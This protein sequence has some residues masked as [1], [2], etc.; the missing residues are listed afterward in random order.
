MQPANLRGCKVLA[1]PIHPPEHSE[2]KRAPDEGVVKP[3]KQLMQAPTDAYWP[4]GQ[5]GTTHSGA[6]EPGAQTA[7]G[8]RNEKGHHMRGHQGL[9]CL[10]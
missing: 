8:E 10:H 7:N 3:C 4:C 6:E 5:V 9:L 1:R 2:A